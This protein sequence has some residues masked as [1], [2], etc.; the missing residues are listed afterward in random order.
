[1][2]LL[3]DILGRSYTNLKYSACPDWT[4]SLYNF[5]ATFLV[6][7]HLLDVRLAEDYV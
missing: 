7:V 1:M 3:G 5:T 6:N 4:G 2:I